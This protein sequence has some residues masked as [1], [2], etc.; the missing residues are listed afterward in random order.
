MQEEAEGAGLEVD[1]VKDATNTFAVFLRGPGAS[2]S[3]TSSTSRASR[4]SVAWPTWWSPGLEWPGSPLPPRRAGWAP[5]P[6]VFEKLDRPGG[7]MRLS[8]GVIWRHRDFERFREECPEGDE[9]LQRLLF[10]RLDDDLAWLESLGATVLA[11]ETG[12][13]LTT[14]ARFD[15]EG[16]TAALVEA[17][18]ASTAGGAGVRVAARLREPPADVPLVLATGGFAADRELLRST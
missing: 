6:L 18:G 3:S 10:E 13:P 1:D 16:L 7:S 12:N 14:G 15:P 17:A 4:S 11:R 5:S 2:A 8:S 9:R